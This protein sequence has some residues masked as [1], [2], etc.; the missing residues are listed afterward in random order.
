MAYAHK[1]AASLNTHLAT[2]SYVTGCARGGG[3]RGGRCPP[4]ESR[5]RHPRP[6]ARAG[7]LGG[8]PG[9]QIAMR[10]TRAGG[11]P[12]PPGA[13]GGR[14]AA[15]P[16]VDHP[17][18]SAPPPPSYQASRDDLAVYAAL[19][20][21][22]DAKAAPHAARWYSHITAL[23][24]AAF[25]GKPAGV[26]VSGAPAAAAAPAAKA[27][28]AG[29]DSDSD[30]E[31]LDLFGDMTPEEQAAADAKKKVI[32][33]AKARGAAK[34]KLTKSMIV[35][36]VKPWDDETDLAAMEAEVRAI[37]KDGLLW[38]A[39]KLV[40]IG[41]GIKKM[42]ITAIIEGR[43]DEGGGGGGERGVVGRFFVFFRAPTPTLPLSLLPFRRQGRVHGRHHRGGA[44]ARR[45]VGQHPGA[46]EEERVWSA[47]AR[48]TRASPRSRPPRPTTP[49]VDRHLLVQQ[50]LTPSARGVRVRGVCGGGGRWPRSRACNRRPARVR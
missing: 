50:A 2:R 9:G 22:P 23:L 5:R 43:G 41:Y 14:A 3:A 36:D 18:P 49:T 28:A 13:A 20:A 24:G 17:P 10:A 44:G 37:V 6:R 33:E 11:A 19:P 16:P 1:D 27:A 8:P 42:Q 47:R 7:G 35:L 34:A 21:A 32:E 4:R 25:P 40:P 46:G 39:S 45:R 29:S 48:G 26:A 38:G 15:A 12:P 31:E 30:D